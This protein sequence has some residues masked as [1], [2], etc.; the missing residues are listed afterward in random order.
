MDAWAAMT[1]T[2][3][4]DFLAVESM[5]RTDSDGEIERQV[6]DVLEPLPIDHKLE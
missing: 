5:A 4:Q 6:A 3:V 2:A 1:P